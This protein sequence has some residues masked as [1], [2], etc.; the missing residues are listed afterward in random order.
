MSRHISVLTPNGFV[1][2]WFRG[3]TL[4]FCVGFGLSERKSARYDKNQES[5]IIVAYA[6]STTD[7]CSMK[8]LSVADGLFVE[9]DYVPTEE[10]P[11]GE[12]LEEAQRN[13]RI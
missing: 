13:K 11:D 10:G 6:Q 1:N 4:N 12:V 9:I 2:T 5:E 3:V 7:I 8:N